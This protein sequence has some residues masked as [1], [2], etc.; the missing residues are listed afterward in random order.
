MTNGRSRFS[1]QVFQA[2]KTARVVDKRLLSRDNNHY[3]ETHEN[4][5]KTNICLVS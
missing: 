4:E 3:M 5:N 2:Q 1:T